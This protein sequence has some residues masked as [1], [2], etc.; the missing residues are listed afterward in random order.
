MIRSTTQALAVARR[1]AAA[2]LALLPAACAFFEPAPPASPLIGTWVTADRDR[3][4]FRTDTIIL[5]PDKGPQTTMSA[6]ECNG[7]FRLNYGRMETAPLIALF[8]G[9]P[10]LSARLKAAL[11]RP[12]YPAADMTCDHGGTTY[13]LVGDRDL[14]AIYRDGGVGGMQR[15]SR[16]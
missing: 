15:L 13:L 12:I 16:L 10:D 2:A 3:I 7:V 11:V 5:S 6:A 4:T 9:Q 1:L 14:V 8:P